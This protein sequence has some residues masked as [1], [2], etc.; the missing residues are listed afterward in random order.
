MAERLVHRPRWGPVDRTRRRHEYRPRWGS[1]DRARRRHVDG[2][3]R[4]NVDRPGRRSFH[5]PWRR[6]VYWPR[7]RSVD[8]S[9]GWTLYRPGRRSE[10]GTRRWLVHWANRRS[11]SKQHS[12]PAGLPQ[13]AGEARYAPDRGASSQRLGAL[14][15]DGEL[16]LTNGWR[17]RGLRPLWRTRRDAVEAGEVREVSKV[18]ARLRCLRGGSPTWIR[19]VT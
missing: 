17:L 6:S 13:R 14:S 2:A 1:I 5:R 7:W 18:F 12:A 3:R 8:R 16:R 9:R 19:Y 11:V 10:H 4:R 15:A